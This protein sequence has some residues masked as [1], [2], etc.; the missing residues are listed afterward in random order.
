MCI[1]KPETRPQSVSV[2][3]TL[4][5]MLKFSSEPRTTR[6]ENLE[7]KISS[8]DIV[9]VKGYGGFSCLECIKL[10][11]VTMIHVLTP[12]AYGTCQNALL[13]ASPSFTNEMLDKRVR[14]S[15]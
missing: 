7:M 14:F 10:I 6:D 9:V 1:P 11:P 13:V 3:V 2:V 5:T 4:S 8:E 12:N 15:A